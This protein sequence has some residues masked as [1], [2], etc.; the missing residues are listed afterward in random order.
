MFAHSCAN[1]GYSASMRAA[2]DPRMNEL[3]LFAQITSAMV[4][5]ESARRADYP[6]FVAA[7]SRNLQ[8]WTVIAADVSTE[9]NKL[10]KELRARIFQLAEF[11]RTTTAAILSGDASAA[12]SILIDINRDIMSGLQTAP[13]MNGGPKA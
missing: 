13:L 9:G 5:T 12:A 4:E 2:S 3:R 10:P 8:L 11:V 6:A 1:Q 7:L